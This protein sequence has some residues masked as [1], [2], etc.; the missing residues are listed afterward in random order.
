MNT[1]IYSTS[2]AS[3]GVG[4]AIPVDTLASEVNMLIRDG[5]IV[6]PAIGISYLSSSLAKNIGINKGILVMDVPENSPA[7]AAGLRGTVRQVIS[8]GG[9]G[10]E[11]GDIIVA[12]DSDRIDNETDLFKALEKHKV[13]DT[14]TLRVLRS[15]EVLS[16]TSSPSPEVQLPQQAGGGGAEGSSSDRFTELSIQLK[17]SPSNSSPAPA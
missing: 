16:A 11:L 1:A 3:A 13:G 4:F 12:I 6:R 14:V 17:L 7:R 8:D 5:R 2:G 10:I 15:K 9:S